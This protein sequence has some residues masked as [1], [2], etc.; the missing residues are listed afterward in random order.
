MGQRKGEI[1]M[2]EVVTPNKSLIEYTVIFKG[3]TGERLN[4]SFEFGG[5]EAGHEAI[6]GEIVTQHADV[7]WSNVRKLLYT[8]SE[9]MN[10]NVKIVSHEG[11]AT[12]DEI[13]GLAQT[14]ATQPL[15]VIPN[16]SNSVQP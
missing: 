8:V 2:S 11:E 4:G 6:L 3:D 14:Y 5:H 9:L 12:G 10:N 7:D 16:E 13:V 1:I 15:D